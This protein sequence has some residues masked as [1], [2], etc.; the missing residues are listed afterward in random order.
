MGTILTLH[1]PEL[2]VLQGAQV[3]LRL[4]STPGRDDRVAHKDVGEDRLLEPHDLSGEASQENW[5]QRNY[6]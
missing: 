6:H 4:Q 1:S 2:K 3:A 5:K